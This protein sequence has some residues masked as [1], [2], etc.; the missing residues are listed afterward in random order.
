[1]IST[2]RGIDIFIVHISFQGSICIPNEAL[3]T[4][5]GMGHGV[6][7]AME[8]YNGDDLLFPSFQYDPQSNLSSIIGFSLDDN[9]KVELSHDAEPVRIRF[10]QVIMFTKF[11]SK[12][13]IF[14]PSYLDEVSCG[15][16]HLGDQLW[17]EEGCHLNVGQSS[18]EETVCDCFHLTSF[19][20][21]MDWTGKCF[22]LSASPSLDILTK[23][24]LVAK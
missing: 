8:F 23:V 22:G 12:I 7:T 21:F 13:L 6:A 4:T 18:F 19:N 1:M 9:S 10:K 17:S 20:L 5:N 14:Q 11:R 3:S 15:F 24:L 2:R 16:W